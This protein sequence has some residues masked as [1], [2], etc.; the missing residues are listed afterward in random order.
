MCLRRETILRMG[1]KIPFA[2]AAMAL[3]VLDFWRGGGVLS[4]GKQAN[5]GHVA[6]GRVYGEA[7]HCVTS[8][9]RFATKEC[10][11]SS[12]LFLVSVVEVGM[13]WVFQQER[14]PPSVAP[15]CATRT[16]NA[17]IQE[18]TTSSS[19]PPRAHPSIYTP[20][21]LCPHAHLSVLCCVFTQSSTHPNPRQAPET[22]AP[23][24]S[25]NKINE[26]GV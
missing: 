9:T 26:G 17:A 4:S 6:R 1:G 23:C 18:Q 22:K 24:P 15:P 3:F 20:Y 10:D 5:G 7:S 13:C 25:P 8:I 2:F 14:Y 19:S 16:F 12:M 21:P 11:E